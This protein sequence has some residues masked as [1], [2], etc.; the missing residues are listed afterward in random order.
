[1]KL[2]QLFTPSPISVLCHGA[3]QPQNI[4]FLYKEGIPV[5]AKVRLP[6]YGPSPS[7]WTSPTCASPRP[8]PLMPLHHPM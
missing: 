1:M 7:W 2:F 6:C 4:V 3:P 5:D 8:P